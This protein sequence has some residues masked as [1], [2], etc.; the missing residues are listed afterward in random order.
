MRS[1]L[2]AVQSLTA[3]Y[4]DTSGFLALKGLFTSHVTGNFVTLG[5]A[6][7][8]GNS[9]ALAKTMALPMFCLAVLASRLLAL[10]LRAADRPVL[11]SLLQI[12][13]LLLI[14]AAG[15]AAWLGPF[16]DPDAG[17]ALAVGMTLV[18]AMAVQNAA[19]RVHLAHTPPSTIM[20]GTT[21]QIMLDAADLLHGLRPETAAATRTRLRRLTLSVAV[22]ASGCGLAALLYQEL[23]N[24]CFCVLPILGAC[25]LLMRT[26]IADADSRS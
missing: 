2:P 18:A 23:S 20:T 16:P 7:V 19:Y 25:T 21:T 14:V 4:A 17:P 26:Q 11:R 8:F 3:G 13:L 12:Q 9:G 6:L 24:W 1:S 22:F 10:R 5:S 15:L